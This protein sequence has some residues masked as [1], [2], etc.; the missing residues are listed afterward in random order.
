MSWITAVSLNEPADRRAWGCTTICIE[1]ELPIPPRAER[2]ANPEFVELLKGAKLYLWGGNDMEKLL[3][4]HTKRICSAIDSY[5]TAHNRA[6]IASLKDDIYNS[7][8][9]ATQVNTYTKWV[10]QQHGYDALEL[11]IETTEV[12]AARFRWLNQLIEEYGGTV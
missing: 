10:E 12:Q 6:V 9:V 4:T 5:G 7:I 1:T 3:R 2:E 11:A 8:S